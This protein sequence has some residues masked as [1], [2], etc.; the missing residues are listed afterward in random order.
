V[1]D[2]KGN[3]ICWSSS[4]SCGFKGA[5]KGTPFAS[6]ISAESAIKKAIE[7]GISQVDIRI[8]GAGP[9]REMAIRIIYSLG[10]VVTSIKDIT[11]LPHNGCRPS[12]KRR[13]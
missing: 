6:Q 13:I 10:I 5:R 9:G 12:K 4:G 2:L 11:P 3:V 8:N 7:L 1:T